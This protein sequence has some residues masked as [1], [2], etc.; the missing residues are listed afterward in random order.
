MGGITACRA[1]TQVI[2]SLVPLN[3]RREML[4][5]IG[6]GKK[7][8]PECIT[9]RQLFQG[10]ERSD[11]SSGARS[12]SQRLRWRHVAEETPEI[13]AAEQLQI[14]ITNLRRLSWPS[15]RIPTPPRHVLRHGG[16]GPC[17]PQL[18]TPSLCQIH[19]P[20]LIL[21]H[22]LRSKGVSKRVARRLNPNLSSG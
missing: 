13:I 3:R 14:R 17:P 5:F 1:E 2:G 15:D 4:K 10:R 11:C 6:W 18:L 12:S 16:G 22:V 19:Q 8:A 20:M 7:S 9:Q 21:A